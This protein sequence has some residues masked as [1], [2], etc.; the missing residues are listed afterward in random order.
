[1]RPTHVLVLL[2]LCS[3]LGQIGHGAMRQQCNPLLLMVE[4]GGPSSDGSGIEGLT[5]KISKSFANEGVTVVN[6][7]NGPFWTAIWHNYRPKQVRE[8]VQR[9]KDSRFW[10]VV[11]VGHSLGAATAWHLAHSVPTSLLVTLDGVSFNDNK[12]MPANA[13]HWRNVWVDRD[14]FGPDWRNEPNADID[15]SI[16]DFRHGDVQA[17]WSTK[18][19][20]F[21][22]V[23]DAVSLALEC[24]GTSGLA[25]IPKELCKLDAIGCAARWKLTDG[26]RDGHGID[27]RFFEYDIGWNRVSSW[28]PRTIPSGESSTFRLACAGPAN[29]VCY[30]GK[31]PSGHIWGVGMDGEDSCERCCISC[32]HAQPIESVDFASN[33]LTCR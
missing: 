32:R 22:S 33:R 17:M 10:P 11:I 15:Y 28:N 18:S 19:R 14:A 25:P 4:G 21:G 5:T 1:M 13:R 9:I 7:D 26:C 3:I 27:V 20:A 2:A 16:G 12:S 30:G 8:A 23:A 29:W 31:R 6:V 24:P